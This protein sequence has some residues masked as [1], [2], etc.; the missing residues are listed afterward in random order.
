MIDMPTLVRLCQSYSEM[1]DAV[2]SQLKTFLDAPDDENA[3]L[4][5]NAVR[6]FTS[7]LEDVGHATHEF[8]LSDEAYD[9]VELAK[10][11]QPG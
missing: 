3:D 5:P 2:T 4:N 10:E 11:H 8:D 6:L 9:Y 7:W 1:G